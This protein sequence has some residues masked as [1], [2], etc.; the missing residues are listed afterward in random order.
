M[1]NFENKTDSMDIERGLGFQ[2]MDWKTYLDKAFHKMSAS[3]TTNTFSEPA[4]RERYMS[5]ES[6]KRIMAKSLIYR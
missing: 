6:I 4:K 3:G 5:V 1:D 2:L